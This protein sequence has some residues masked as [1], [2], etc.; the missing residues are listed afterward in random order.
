MPGD[1]KPAGSRQTVGSEK[2]SVTPHALDS[3]F[4]STAPQGMGRFEVLC[5]LWAQKQGLMDP[6]S[7]SE[8]PPGPK[9]SIPTAGLRGQPLPPH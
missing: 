9:P 6:T 8:S 2:G 4:Q 1:S 7:S 5:L 3:R